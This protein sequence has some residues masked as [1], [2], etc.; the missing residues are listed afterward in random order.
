VALGDLDGDGRDDLV[1][2]D[3][4]PDA[5]TAGVSCPAT[6][7]IANAHPGSDDVVA[8][9]ARSGPGGV[10]ASWTSARVSGAF[11]RLNGDNLGVAIYDHDGD[12]KRDVAVFGGYQDTRG[13]GVAFLSGDGHGQFTER[14]TRPTSYDRRYGARIDANQ[15]GCDDLIVVGGDGRAGSFGAMGYSVAEV[16][17]GGV[18]Q[19][20]VRAWTSGSELT[21]SIPNSNP[22]RV[23]VGDFDGD[24]LLDFAV[25]Q[26]FNTKERFSNDQDDGPIEGVAVY[27]NRSR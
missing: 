15:D 25:D 8:W 12:G 19:A 17:L 21:S 10:P 23:A 6:S 2:V 20:P 7:G 24:G 18:T 27:L 14:F 5:C 9:V 13:M 3:A 16:Y 26:S 22:G 1:V 4:F 11:G